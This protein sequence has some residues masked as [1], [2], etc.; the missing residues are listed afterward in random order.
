MRSA[1]KGTNASSTAKDGRLAV[2]VAAERCISR[3]GVRKTTMDDVA[4]EAGMSRP[5]IYRF[6]ADREQLL[7]ALT[8]KH[9]QALVEKTH[10]YIARH[11]NFE[12]ALVEGLLYLS[13]HGRRDPF[14]RL[15]VGRDESE[16][17]HR[18]G[19][20]DTAASLTAE[21]WDPLL[22]QAEKDGRMRAGL[23]RDQLHVWLANIGLMLMSLLEKG[24]SADAL[25][26]LVRDLVVPAFV[27]G[28]S[29]Y[30]SAPRRI[31][32]RRSTSRR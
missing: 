8:T 16:F 23:D 26:Q 32:G 5:S 3:Y 14:T 1:S 15:L 25:R 28:V 9:S 30:K 4:R 2:M 13:E 24:D 31:D 11:D 18:F 20:T 27:V 29:G 6:F 21:F 19:V 22:D 12:D 10:A 7:V 17:A